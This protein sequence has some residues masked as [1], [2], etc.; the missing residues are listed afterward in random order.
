MTMTQTQIVTNYE[1]EFQPEIGEA[2]EILPGLNWV[3]LPLPFMLGHINVW[4]LQDG[5]GWVVVDTGIFTQTT[6]DAWQNLFTGFMNNEPLSRVVVTHLHPDHVGCA[7]W[8]CERFGIELYMPRDEYLFC[9][10]LVSDTGLPVPSEGRRFYQAAGFS[11]KDMFRYIEMFGGYGKVVAQ[12]PRSYHR[13]HEGVT[14]NIGRYEWQVITGHGH[15]PEHACLYNPEL[16]VLI[17]GDQILPTISPNVSVYPTEPAANPLAGWFESLHRIKSLLPD[18]VLVLPAH[19]KPFRGVKTRLDE[20]IEEH[21]TGL[22]KLRQ[23][24]SKPQRAVDVF[25]VLFKSKITD[26][27]L[28]MA[29]GE[30]V[31]HLNYL[32]YEGEVSINTDKN[33]NRWYQIRH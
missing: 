8:L 21:E 2:V 16:N 33:G 29:T 4:L 13:L 12:L 10:I 24:C 14:V 1:Y 5:D 19:G 17:S 23:L 26:D 6:R 7:G 11:E 30:A 9:R 31:A 25:P 27:N 22:E 28:M 20:L 18:D 32:L 3:R 15:S